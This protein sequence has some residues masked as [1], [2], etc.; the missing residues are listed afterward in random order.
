M[1]G[2]RVLV[3][4]IG[5][6]RR[7]NGGCNFI[8]IVYGQ[9]YGLLRHV[10][11]RIG[12]NYGER[13]TGLCLVI[14]VDVERNFAGGCIDVERIGI[15]ARGQTPSDCLRCRCTIDSLID[16][17]V[18]VDRCRSRSGRYLCRILIDV[19]HSERDRLLGA[20]ACRIGCDDRERIA[21]LNLEIWVF[22]QGYRAARC[23][24]T[25]YCRISAGGQ[26]VLS[27]TV[28]DVT[29][30]RTGGDVH[31]LAC[32]RVFVNCIG[33][34]RRGNGWRDFIQ[35]VD[36]QRHNLLRAVA[37]C[38]GCDNR[39][40]VIRLGFVVGVCRQGHHAGARVDT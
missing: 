33:S 15:P 36:S 6:V 19:V 3:Y 27:R 29:G 23:I 7:G 28:A 12:G 22:V 10:A 2:A 35:I 21:R 34:C 14:R 38:I 11:G 31:Q 37:G 32:A 13:I 40:C 18:F 8:Q 25:K 1:T 24:D 5:S 9:R 39:E 20:V 16:S 17:T 4:G 30:V 26:A